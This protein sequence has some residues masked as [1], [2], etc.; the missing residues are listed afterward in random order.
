MLSAEVAALR[1]IGPQPDFNGRR[2]AFAFGYTFDGLTSEEQEY[3]FEISLNGGELVCVIDVYSAIDA[4]P[5]E[6]FDVDAWEA[7]KICLHASVNRD[8]YR[9]M[10]SVA[11]AVLGGRRV[12]FPNGEVIHV[13]ELAQ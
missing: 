7:G 13:K 10:A 4:C 9:S 3:L 11:R 8:N 6:E 1:R 5:A 2:M 12:I